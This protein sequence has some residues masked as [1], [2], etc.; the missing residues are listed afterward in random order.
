M[1]KDVEKLKLQVLIVLPFDIYNLF[2]DL[3]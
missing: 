1:S 3:F 2:N